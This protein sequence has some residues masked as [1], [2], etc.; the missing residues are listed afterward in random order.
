MRVNISAMGSLTLMLF[1]LWRLL[2]HLPAGLDDAWKQAAMG[3]LPERDARNAEL[4]HICFR[5]AV[6]HVAVMHPRWAGVQRELP[7]LCIQLVRALWGDPRLGQLLFHSPPLS[8][9]LVIL[10]A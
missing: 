10:L 5:S 7:E 9:V 2:P 4:P 8:G 1:P 3:K 6:D